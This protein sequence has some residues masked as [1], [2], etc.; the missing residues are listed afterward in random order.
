MRRL[1]ACNAVA[2]LVLATFAAPL[3]HLHTDEHGEA[4]LHAHFPELEIADTDG[5]QHLE[6]PHSHGETRSIDIL[7]TTAAHPI[8]LDAVIL[9]TSATFSPRPEFRAFVSVAVPWAHAPPEFQVLIPRA[10]PA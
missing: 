6:P 2:V 1:I 10:P 3:F 8:H 5:A 7:T 9:N 4:L